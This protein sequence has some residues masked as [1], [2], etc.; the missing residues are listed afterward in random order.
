VADLMRLVAEP[1][2]WRL[3]YLPIEPEQLDY[4]TG[5]ARELEPGY[6]PVPGVSPWRAAARRLLDWFGSLSPQSLTLGRDRTPFNAAL[7]DGLRRNWEGE[8]RA[9]LESALPAALGRSA[10]EP[11]P[12]ILERYRMARRSLAR[13]VPATRELLHLGLRQIFVSTEPHDQNRGWPGLIGAW[14]SRLP[15]AVRDEPQEDA[16]KL[17][18]GACVD[19]EEDESLDD[20]LVELGYPPT[21][22]WTRDYTTEILERVRLARAEMDYADFMGFYPVA[23]HL[24]AATAVELIRRMLWRSE[25]GLAELE[26]VLQGELEQVAL[27]FLA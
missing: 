26:E 13:S 17:L 22:A 12:V 6:Q 20:L 1:E 16:L 15:R 27:T 8:E 21:T 14:Y 5:L 23:P 19:A 7:I 2:R 4:L 3:D 11:W 24:R 9:L 10:A 18:L 25:L